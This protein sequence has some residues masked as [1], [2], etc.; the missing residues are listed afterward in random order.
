VKR[1]VALQSRRQHLIEGGADVHLIL[2]EGILRRT[3]GAA[4]VM[5]EQLEHLLAVRARSW[6]RL[7]VLSLATRR[8]VLTDSFTV[9]SFA[10][11]TDTDVAYFCGL[12]GQVVR[13]ERE[14]EVHAT[15]AGFDQLSGAALSPSESADLIRALLRQASG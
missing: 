2:D 3:I 7:R 14:V 13:Q 5:A 6:L 4:G 15:R 8:A 11:S 1:L 12:R 9:L 10:N